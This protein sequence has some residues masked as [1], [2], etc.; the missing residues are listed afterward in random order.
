MTKQTPK[1]GDAV[2]FHDSRGRAH[3][4]LV[5]GVFGETRVDA[6]GSYE[7]CMNIVFVSSDTKRSDSYGRQI[8]RGPTSIGHGSSNPG[9][10]NYWRR[11]DEEPNPIVAPNED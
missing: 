9:H 5:T 1:I 2:I 11:P 4:A 6:F 3:N 10:G 7:P 8:E